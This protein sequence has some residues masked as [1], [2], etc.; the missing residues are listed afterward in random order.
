MIQIRKLQFED[1]PCAQNLVLDENWN[2]TPNDWEI[3]IQNPR[4]I[5][6]A[7][8]LDEN[9]VGTASAIT[10]D[11]FVAW[12]GMLLVKREYRGRSIGKS[13]LISLLDQLHGITTVK[14]DATPAGEPIYKKLG[15]EEEYL[16]NR[17]LGLNFS[18][19]S[20][21]ACDHF[22]ETIRE[23]DIPAIIEC[24]KRTFGADRSDLLSAL[25]ANFPE[26]SLVLKQDNEIV[27]FC[28]VR[29]GNKYYQIGPVVAKTFEHTQI[30]IHKALHG[31]DGQPVIIDIL[32]DKNDLTEWLLELG[33]VKQRSFMR[34][35]KA[36]NDT[37]G[38]NNLYQA[39]CGPEYG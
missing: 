2:Q 21:K 22:P 7:A 13:L 18:I 6:L 31:L 33:F 9:L 8:E 26:K 38:L 24:D 28:L 23:K 10:Y 11:N 30:L 37:M 4:N 32:N 29:K 14:L 17:M 1:I 5:C 36:S 39:I 25:I 19:G 20:I 34:M 27:A 15:F 12:I 35:F 16:I 3:L